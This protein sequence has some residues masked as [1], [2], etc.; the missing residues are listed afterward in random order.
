MTRIAIPIASDEGLSSKVNEHFS[1]SDYYAILD[2]KSGRI[3]TVKVISNPLSGQKNAA[4]LLVRNKVNLVLAG[5]IGSCAI[6]ILLDGGA[7]LFSDAEGT[8]EG[9]LKDYKDGKLREILTAGYTL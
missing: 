9:A 1:M 4:E 8:V 5:R 6:K 3:T 7:R 2:V